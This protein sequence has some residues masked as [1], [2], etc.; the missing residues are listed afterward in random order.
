[1][2]GDF[3]QIIPFVIRIER[4]EPSFVIED[5]AFEHLIS[6]VY[7][8]NVKFW[9]RQALHSTQIFSILPSYNLPG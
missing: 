9:F 2:S 5:L 7:F 1:M 4:S 3:H 8:Q 6:S